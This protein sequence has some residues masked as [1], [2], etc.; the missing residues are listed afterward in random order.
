MAPR[1]SARS[2]L[3]VAATLAGTCL[4]TNARIVA[5]VPLLRVVVTPWLVS[6]RPAARL[7]CSYSPLHLHAARE[8]AAACVG[9][10]L[11]SRSWRRGAGVEMVG[12]RESDF[13]DGKASIYRL[14]KHLAGWKVDWA[15]GGDEPTTPLQDKR[16][17]EVA[18]DASKVASYLQVSEFPKEM[19]AAIDPTVDP[20]DDFYE[21]ACG[22][23]AESKGVI[24]DKDSVV[25]VA[26]QWDQ[27]DERIEK[28]M[29]HVFETDE[30]GTA[31]IFYR[32][33]IKGTTAI[34]AWNLLTPWMDLA[35]TLDGNSSFTEAMIEIQNADMSVFWT[36]SVNLD[37]WNKQRYALF[38]QGPRTMVAAHD[39]QTYAETGVETEEMEGLRAL[40][41]DLVGLAGYDGMTAANDADNVLSIELQL[42]MGQ[43]N[44]SGSGRAHYDQWVDREYLQ[45]NA[46]SVGWERWFKA[47]NFSRIG[48]DQDD[49]D[50]EGGAIG[51]GI[52]LDEAG[53]PLDS[54]RL[55]VKQGDWL[56]TLEDII[57]CAGYESGDG[58][59]DMEACWDRIESYVR[60]K[61]IYNYAPYLDEDFTDTVH[62][63]HNTR[64]GA[65]SQKQRW[66][67][68][69]S[70]TT[71]LL[72]WASSYL[73]VE[74]TFPKSRKQDTLAMLDTIRDEF[75]SSLDGIRWM[76]PGSRQG[77]KEK[78]D[79]MF[80]EVGYPDEWPESVMRN[81]GQMV[82]DNYA[83]NVDTIG[84]NAV[85]R[86]RVR[87]FETPARNRWGESYP[88]V[89]N[90][91]YSPMV[92]GLWVPAGIIQ[93]PFYSE[94][95][96]QARN[97]GSL[98]TI[99]GHE[100]THGFDDTGHL[101]DKNGDQKD[102]WDAST[103][104]EFDER[105]DCLA[106]QYDEYG[107]EVPAWYQGGHVDGRGTLGE[108]IADEGGMRF[109]FQAFQRSFP[110]ERRSM[111]AHRLFFAAFAQN[112]CENDRQDIAVDSLESDE[113]SPAKY[114]VLGVLSNFK[115]FA[116][117]FNCPVGTNMNPKN[118][119]ELW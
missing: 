6:C 66:K 102:W 104:A 71:Y 94:E 13:S 111:A 108:N 57:S 83:A 31:A 30:T 14:I 45:M 56:E 69:Y 116:Q 78:L 89:V 44:F 72:G 40:V 112:W 61:L 65:M 76:D 34:G 24:H 48:L 114:R 70:D 50:V 88:I 33:C 3:A 21:F 26:L 80:F 105:A 106:A 46:P 91:F 75:R 82:A 98:G 73:F 8:V 59:V 37:T 17:A 96:D 20:C 9:H 43:S 67:K 60:F 47:M 55:I 29:R 52:E 107:T 51:G 81:E 4:A 77:A 87:V 58:T 93:T 92:N 27:V 118:K 5:D 12:V 38:M 109:A 68:C 115:P 97:Y 15:L 90:A 41:E 74:K 119:C 28:N 36:W 42:A 85:K 79:N 35:E 23:W 18:Q 99:C 84:Y 113:H 11:I 39:Y 117:A 10:V 25:S 19:M 22:H 64:Y 54:P 63:W 100:M 32:S 16:L 103:F 86:A 101:L 7:Q 49:D 1:A 2:V 95:Y 110:A 53:Q 62:E